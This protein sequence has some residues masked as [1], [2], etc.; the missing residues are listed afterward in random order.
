MTGST[1][2][3]GTD[4]TGTTGGL[5]SPDV[6]RQIEDFRNKF[7]NAF[8]EIKDF[9]TTNKEPIIAALTAITTAIVG[10]KL[11]MNFGTILATLKGVGI[12]I[13]TIFAGISIPV[14]IVIGVIAALAG[15]FTYLWRTNETFRNLV[16]DI[17]QGIKTFFIDLWNNVLVPFGSWL[18][19]VFV[20]AW[21]GATKAANWLYRNVLVPLG[22]FLKSFWDNVLVPIGNVIGD[23]LVIAFRA[24]SRVA[25]SLWRNVMVPLGEFFAAIFVPLI[26]TLS[27]IFEFLWK[28]VLKPFATFIGEL[29]TPIFE[30][31]GTKLD[32]VWQN[33]LKPVA[34]F[35]ADVF[36]VSFESAFE[37]IGEII[38][39]LEFIF[40]NV[41]NF[42]TNIFKGNWSDAWENIKNIFK[43]VFNI[44]EDILK[45]VQDAFSNIINFIMNTFTNNW[46]SV[47][48]NVKD[49][50]KGVFNSLYGIV[51][52]PINLIIGA[53]NKMIN[54]LNKINIKV[55]SWVSLIPGVPSG[56]SSFGFSIPTIPKLA[57]G[58]IVSSPTLSMIGEAG[59][60][61]VVPL[62]NTSFIDTLA[63]AIGN[64]VLAAMQFNQPTDSSSGDVILNIDSTEL[65]RVII[66]AINKENK[67]IGNTII[68]GVG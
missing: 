10:L 16:K 18:G 54:G 48:E 38:K 23:V 26:E 20:K 28:E 14:L 49:I 32:W 31:F 7:I 45:G 58:G 29:L 13:A 34:N 53:I 44:M 12:V 8:T 25:S 51:K 66:P 17:W 43:G 46:S 6:T 67:R 22:R 65:A 24:L 42:I 47:W 62:E 56:I 36:V 39:D 9:L 11:A 30:D 57:R 64:A 41:L 40:T 37:L 63:G 3:L 2:N 27:T 50:F 60:E 5:L 59:T 35:I 15:V 33:V 19:D 52:I 21:D 55:P 1:P 4:T 61:A 68:Q